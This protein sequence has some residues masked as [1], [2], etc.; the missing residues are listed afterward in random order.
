[1]TD[2]LSD[3]RDAYLAVVGQVLHHLRKRQRLTQGELAGAA[4]ISQSALSRF[5]TG[6]TLPDLFELRGLAQALGT[7]PGDLVTLIE[8][9]ASSTAEVMQHAPAVRSPAGLAAVARLGLAALGG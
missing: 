6:Q 3:D 2:A 1:M 9:A 8:R 4:D 5:E 7:T